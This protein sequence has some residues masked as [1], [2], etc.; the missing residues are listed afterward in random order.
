MDSI[1]KRL[2]VRKMQLFIEEH[3]KEPI[4]LSGLAKASGYSPYYAAKLF[5]E[6][7]GKP[8]F[9]YI[10][11]LRLAKAAEDIVG[12]AKIVDVAF[13]FVFDSHE[14]FTRAFFKEFQK[15]PAAHRK[16]PGNIKRFIPK[17]VFNLY[18]S[19][20]KGEKSMSKRKTNLNAVFVQILDR[21]ARKLILKRG[22]K[23]TH[24][25]EYCE[26]AG[27]EIDSELSKISGALGEPMGL[28]LPKSLVKEGTSTY[29]QGVEVAEDFLGKIPEGFEIVTLPPCKMMV[30]Q[31]PPF[32]DEKFEEAIADFTAAIKNNA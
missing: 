19:A 20:L 2:A 7:T 12:G 5:A 26:E 22:K 25:F 27:C 23:A 14:G 32:E 9:Q 30:F 29:V 24:Y 10:R 1:D 11:A 16:N 21:P 6:Y 3:L 15:T 31:G 18:L 17:S 4:T 8:P 28:W 13:D